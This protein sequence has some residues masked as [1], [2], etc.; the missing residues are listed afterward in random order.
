MSSEKRMLLQGRVVVILITDYEGTL[1]L[2]KIIIMST[3]K[4]FIINTAIFHKHMIH[5][6]IVILQTL[7]SKATY[8][9]G[10]HKA[11]NLEEAN[12]QRKCP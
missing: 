12:K 11:I 3:H 5:L 6:D 2:K 4:L 9:W 8:N 1:L 10:I 7:L